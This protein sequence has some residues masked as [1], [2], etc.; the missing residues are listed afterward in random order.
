MDVFTF[1]D[2]TTSHL[3]AS[4]LCHDRV[5]RRLGR[6]DVSWACWERAR[7]TPGDRERSGRFR[8]RVHLDLRRWS[9]GS[10][11]I[12]QGLAPALACAERLAE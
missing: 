7:T 12:G 5:T 4:L 2:V 1:G 11:Q 3:D 8:H 6:Q 10:G 9:I